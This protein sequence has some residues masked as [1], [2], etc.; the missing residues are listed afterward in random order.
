MRTADISPIRDR[1]R[2]AIW[3]HKQQADQA[4]ADLAHLSQRRHLSHVAGLEE[5]LRIVEEE[6]TLQLEE[7]AD[8]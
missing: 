2:D 1:L 3:R 4:A 7:P 8:A 6:S 5:A